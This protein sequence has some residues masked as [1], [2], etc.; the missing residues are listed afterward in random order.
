MGKYPQNKAYQQDII[1]WILYSRA[2][3]ITSH[4]YL[5]VF[6]PGDLCCQQQIS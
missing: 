2:I 3:G 6:L 1:L 4:A 5:K